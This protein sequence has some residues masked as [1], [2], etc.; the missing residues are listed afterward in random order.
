MVRRGFYLAPEGFGVG[1]IPHTAFDFLVGPDVGSDGNMYS[2]GLD[3]MPVLRSGIRPRGGKL[4]PRKR[5][6]ERGRTSRENLARRNLNV[7]SR[8]NS[9]GVWCRWCRWY[10][11]PILYVC[12]KKL[13]YP[14]TEVRKQ[15]RSKTHFVGC[16]L[17][18]GNK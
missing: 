2:R 8:V 14:S 3:T 1:L 4:P 15:R 5:F 12:C 17:Y 16:V 18:I 6:I 10:R 11:A 9:M 7:M 13:R